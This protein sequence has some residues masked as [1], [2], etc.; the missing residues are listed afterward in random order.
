MWKN[1]EILKLDQATVKSHTVFLQVSLLSE[2]RLYN[3]KIKTFYQM[4]LQEFYLSRSLVLRGKPQGHCDTALSFSK[5]LLVL[6]CKTYYP[7][8]G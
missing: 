3:R 8:H 6:F 1:L 2:H 4:N 7:Q 5:V